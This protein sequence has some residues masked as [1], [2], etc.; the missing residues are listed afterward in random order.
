MVKVARSGNIPAPLDIDVAET[1][2]FSGR[3]VV[4][5]AEGSHSGHLQCFFPF[6]LM[7]PARREGGLYVVLRRLITNLTSAN[8]VICKTGRALKV[9]CL[10]AE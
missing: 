3:A 2:S 5:L 10:A 1:A 4:A 8:K 6:V 9:D 7:S